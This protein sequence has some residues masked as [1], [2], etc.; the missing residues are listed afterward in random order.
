MTKTAPLPA[1][2]RDPAPGRPGTARRVLRFLAVAACLPYISLKIAWVAGGEI[3]IPAGSTLLDNRE[4][5]AAVNAI[6]VVMDA[7]VV[8]LALLLTQGWGRRVPAWLLAF[9]MW[10]AAGLLAPIMIGFPA[11]TVVGLLSGPE[12]AG[13]REPFLDEWVF[14]TVY[15][16]FIVQG[17]ALGTLFALYARDRWGHVWRGTLGDLPARFSGT[18]VRVTAVTA[19]LVALVPTTVHVLWAAG[20]TTGLPTSR[21]TQRDGDFFVLEGLRLLFLALAV[22]Y[23][24]ALVLQWGRWASVRTVL[25]LGWVGSGGVGCWGGYLLL[26]TF[27]PETDPAKQATGLMRLTYAGEMITGFLLA[28]CLAVFLRRRSAGA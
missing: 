15:G 11:Q 10:V 21:I 8:V 5:M 9:P 3:G 13:S 28:G 14:G 12:P 22:A 17:V 7:A 6:S 23:V 18:G 27:L 4:L 20:S 26:V 25:G 1:R 19:T 16:G 24:L 2:L